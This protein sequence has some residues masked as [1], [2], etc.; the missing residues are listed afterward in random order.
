MKTKKCLVLTLYIAMTVFALTSCGLFSDSESKNKDEKITIETDT[1]ATS[2]QA[3]DIWDDE[4]VENK[5]N[6]INALIDQ[7]YYFDV[8]RDKQEEALYD[9]IMAGLDDPY[10]VYYTPDEYAE[11]MEDTSGEYVGIGAVV[12]QNSDKLVSIVR[13][14]PGSPAEEA[15][16]MAEDIVTE[17]DGTEIIDQELSL[18]VDMIRGK[19]GS[20]AHIKIYRPSTKEYMEFDVERRVVENVSVYSEMFDNNVGYIQVQQFYDNTA[21]EFKTALD[22][23]ES[24]GAE[25]VIV[26]MRDN[27]GGLLTAVVDMCDYLMDGGTIVTTKDKNGNVISEYTA[28]D[29]HSI[30]IPMVV[31]TNGNS[32]SA[33]EIFS[34]AMKDTGIAKLVGTTTYGKGIVQSVIPLSDGS[35]VKI[36]VAKYFTPNGT[37]IHKKGIE[38]DYEVELPD[39]RTNAVNLDRAVDTQLDKAEEVIAEMINN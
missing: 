39:G 25:G 2:A 10:S 23:L 7:Y 24:Q 11:L 29:E 13:P 22:D 18:V 8:D 26:D 21:D 4:S 35:A 12:T 37:D 19:E 16:L 36:T 34:G 17:V 15:G 5:I 9:G 27:P 6:D 31:L 20:E 28:T 14:I 33:A 32:A 3:T 1:D 38:P 30:D